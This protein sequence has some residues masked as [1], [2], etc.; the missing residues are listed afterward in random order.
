M[1]DNMQN[2]K[3]NELEENKKKEVDKSVNIVFNVYMKNTTKIIKI[4]K[5]KKLIAKKT[6]EGFRNSNNCTKKSK[7]T[8][9]YHANGQVS[10]H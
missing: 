5:S 7:N 3:Y 1:K 8:L 2:I 9:M 6:K 4:I 10:Y